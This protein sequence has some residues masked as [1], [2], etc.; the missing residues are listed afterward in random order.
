MEVLWGSP[1]GK[2]QS[3]LRDFSSFEFLPTASWAKFSRPCGTHFAVGFHADSK[4]R[5]P[6]RS[7]R[8]SNTA[9]TVL[10]DAVM[11]VSSPKRQNKTF[12]ASWAI[13][14]SPAWPA[15]NVPKEE[16]LFS[17]SKALI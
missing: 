11:L 3:S 4:S 8:Q 5:A 7:T 16:L 9:I 12:T 13:R 15:L 2:F 14:G 1:P 6:S 17:L 10:L